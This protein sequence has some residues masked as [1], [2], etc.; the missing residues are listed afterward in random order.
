M[1]VSSGKVADPAYLRT[2]LRVEPHHESQCSIKEMGTDIA[3]IHQHFM[4]KSNEAERTQECCVEVTQ[5]TE[6]TGQFVTRPTD[7]HCICPAFSNHECVVTIEGYDNGEFIFAVSVPD[8]DA[9]ANIVSSLRE[10]AASVRLDRIT[11]P[12]MTS[13][14]RKLEL[15]TGA[16]TEK[17]REAVETAIQAGYYDTPRQANL[18]DLAAELNISRSAVSQRLTAVESKL[19]AELFVA[20]NGNN[21][22]CE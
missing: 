22:S 17:Q 15:M 20:E 19:V 2:K 9:L 16:I 10:R 1:H 18:S 5:S 12:S 13:H 3:T 7:R 4:A 11:G 6:N 8:R 21:N 14:G